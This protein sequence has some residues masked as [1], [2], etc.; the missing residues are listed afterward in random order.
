MEQNLAD[1]QPPTD[2]HFQPNEVENNDQEVSFNG[3]QHDSKQSET[4][5]VPIKEKKKI[6][7]LEDCPKELMERAERIVKSKFIL[8]TFLK[9]FYCK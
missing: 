5:A 9:D 6:N 4:L 3:E 1:A 2:T 7:M 8:F